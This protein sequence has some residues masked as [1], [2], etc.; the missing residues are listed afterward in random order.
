MVIARISTAE[1]HEQTLREPVN[2]F[3]HMVPWLAATLSKNTFTPS[4]VATARDSKMAK[5]VERMIVY[6]KTVAGRC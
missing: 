2:A 5:R 4:G 6:F 3:E 1:Q